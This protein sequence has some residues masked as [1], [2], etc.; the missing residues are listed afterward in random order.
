MDAKYRRIGGLYILN[1][2][3]RWKNNNKNTI[4]NMNSNKRFNIR[5]LAANTLIVIGLSLLL[6]FQTTVNATGVTGDRESVLLQPII[7]QA[8]AGAVIHL[9][10][11][12]YEGPV[13]IS[14]AL[15][16]IGDDSVTI[17]NEQEQ[18]A[19][20]IQAEGVKLEGFTIEHNGRQPA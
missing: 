18:S 4:K 10:P 19:I 9:E 14:K 16:L 1:V 5:R 15:T 7:D 2:R 11:G 13:L 8:D 12:R 20:S 17:H 3:D 6:V